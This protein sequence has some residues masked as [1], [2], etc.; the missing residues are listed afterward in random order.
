MTA[1]KERVNAA[2]I[3]LG[4]L[5]ILAATFL[6][7]E[8]LETRFFGG[9]NQDTL[10]Y[11]YVS[12]GIATGLLMAAWAAWVIQRHRAKVDARE[13]QLTGRIMQMEKLSALG[14]L[15][16]GF[17]HEINNPVGVLQ[18]RLE[19][20]L[21]ETG[22]APRRKD[23]E[24]LFRNTV[25]IGKTARQFLDFARRSPLSF[26]P[27]DL[28]RVA[29]DVLQLLEKLLRE[30]GIEVVTE[31]PAEFPVIAGC[32]NHLE[33]VVLN[34][35]KNAMEALEGVPRPRIEIS[36]RHEAGRR[37]VVLRIVDNGPGVPD[38]IRSRLFDPFFTTK[39]TGTGLGLSVSYGIVRQHGGTIEI[40]GEPGRNVFRI[41]LPV[42]GPSRMEEESHA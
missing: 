7:W 3:A 27:V 34:V 16:S 24:V 8:L 22:D 41:E 13:R 5:T 33:Q 28:R 21:Q 32:E 30:R 31:W 38:P 6:V 11:L 35:V 25:R 29:E 23:L 26:G 20:M 12:R 40:D 1:W 19:L 42:E 36:G 14:E 17:A 39:K 4:A 15:L 2:G 37:R 9:L 18:G 10:H